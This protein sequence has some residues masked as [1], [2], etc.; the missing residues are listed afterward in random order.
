MNID[1]TKQ[2]VC[3]LPEKARRLSSS[4]LVEIALRG[5]CAQLANE[6]KAIQEQCEFAIAN[7]DNVGLKQ[8]AEIVLRIIRGYK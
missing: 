3:A 8:F 2:T 4:E 7:S 6:Q 5:R 1:K